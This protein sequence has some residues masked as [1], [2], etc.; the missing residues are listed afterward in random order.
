MIRITSKLTYAR[1][2]LLYGAIMALFPLAYVWRSHGFTWPAAAIYLV[3]LL[4]LLGRRYVTVAAYEQDR[5]EITSYLFGIRRRQVFDT[6]TVHVDLAE[7]RGPGNVG[8]IPLSSPGTYS[9]LR[10]T[11]GPL[12][13]AKLSSRNG[14]DKDDLNKL[15]HAINY[16]K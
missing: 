10:V 1:Y 16:V 12:L 5:L 3:L 8:L 9:V 2:L 13:R 7:E 6:A 15:E 11:D 14:F 4:F